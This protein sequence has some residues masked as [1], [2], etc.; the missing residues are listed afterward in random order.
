MSLATHA[1]NVPGEYQVQLYVSNQLYKQPVVAKLPFL[2]HAIDE[3]TEINL[4]HE[5]KN[6]SAPLN[7]VGSAWETPNIV[8]EARYA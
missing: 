8:F 7:R 2:F 4:K 1:Y 3:I 6:N 5:R